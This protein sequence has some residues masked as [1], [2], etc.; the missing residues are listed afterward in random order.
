MGGGLLR[1][2]ALGL[3]LLATGSWA[4]EGTSPQRLWLEAKQRKIHAARSE[5][6][7]VARAALPAVVSITTLQNPSESSEGTDEKSSPQ[8]SLG[9][10]FV[11]HPDGLIVTGYHVVEEAIEINVA[12]NPA[13]DAPEV[14]PATVVGADEQTDIAL[15]KINSRRKLPVLPLGS[16]SRVEIADWVVVIGSPFGMANSV[17][18]GVV[19]YK[20]R[21]GIS[22]NGKDGYFDYL[23]TDA[24]INPG[25]SGGPVLSAEG[26][27]IAIASAVNVAGQGIGFAIP[28]DTAKSVIPQLW[29]EGTVRRAWIGASVRD[30]PD[31]AARNAEGVVVSEVR[32][33]GPA[34]KAGLR[35]GDVITNVGP[36]GIR[37][38]ATLR[39]R[40]AKGA[41][42]EWME[43]GIRRDGQRL[44]LQMRLEETPKP[45]EQGNGMESLATDRNVHKENDSS[46]K[47]TGR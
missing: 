46:A 18:V 23:Q 25:N 2:A 11:I 31:G 7:K 42:G 5:L 30:S 34:S 44:R 40:V 38:A 47:S 6:S 17:T 24:S 32:E 10:G 39:S 45:E 1:C 37:R 26:E 16:A 20:G 8:K 14:Y 43:L 15:L 13:D 19:S 27:V 22:P 36:V 35:I 3:A 9:S 12:L 28:V 33:G 21:S 41:I 4:R 29:A